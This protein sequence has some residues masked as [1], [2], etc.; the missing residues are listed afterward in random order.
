MEGTRTYKITG[1]KVGSDTM[2]RIPNTGDLITKWTFRSVGPESSMRRKITAFDFYIGEMNMGTFAGEINFTHF[3]QKIGEM[4]GFSTNHAHRLNHAESSFLQ[5]EL[6]AIKL[7]NKHKVPLPDRLLLRKTVF[8]GGIHAFIR[9]KNKNVKE[10]FLEEEYSPL[11]YEKLKKENE[12]IQE[13]KRAESEKKMEE[14]KLKEL[15][16]GSDVVDST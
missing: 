7:A 16:P 12:D 8:M 4:V 13:K 3:R 9:I 10:L 2:F 11:L 15:F 1:E 14:E 5:A 6:D